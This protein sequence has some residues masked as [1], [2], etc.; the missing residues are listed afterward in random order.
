VQAE[1]SDMDEVHEVTFGEGKC[2]LG[3]APE[4]WRNVSLKRSTLFVY[5]SC[6]VHARRCLSG[7][8]AC[9]DAPEVGEN[10]A[11]FAG[12]RNLLP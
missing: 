1:G 11:S 10:Q 9:V 4:R 3:E 5:P 7:T 12:G 8:T 6:L 2:F